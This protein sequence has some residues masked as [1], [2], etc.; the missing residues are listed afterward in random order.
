MDAYRLV[1]I[2]HSSIKIALEP[3]RFASRA[4][5]SPILRI[6]TNCLFII[7]NSAI[8]LPSF[9]NKNFRASH[10]SVGKIGDRFR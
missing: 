1:M 9:D 3:L 2:D 4:V 6:K 10:V 5:S 7:F 8:Q